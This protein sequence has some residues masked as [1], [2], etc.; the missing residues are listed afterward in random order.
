MIN[1]KIKF[2][3]ILADYTGVE[4]LTLKVDEKSSIKD[5]IEKLAIKFGETFKTK[6]LNSQNKLNKYIILI[7]NDKDLRFFEGFDT[8]L[9]EDD[10]ITFL[11]VIAGG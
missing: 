5:V 4:E 11:P 9:Q 3:S 6:I 7:L 8:F 2:I 10:E 1:I